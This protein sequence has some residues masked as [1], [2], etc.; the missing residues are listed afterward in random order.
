MHSQD[1]NY[2]TERCMHAICLNMSLGL[3]LIISYDMHLVLL[4]V[5]MLSRFLQDAQAYVV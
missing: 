5:T 1:A 4:I 2:V 3:G